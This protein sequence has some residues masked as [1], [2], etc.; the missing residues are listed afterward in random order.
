VTDLLIQI[1]I[2]FCLGVSVSVLIWSKISINWL[3]NLCRYLVWALPFERIPSVRTVIGN[4]RPSQILVLFGFYLLSILFLK[5]DKDILNH[6]LSSVTFWIIGFFV[7]SASSWFFVSD[8]SRF[9]NTLIANLIV[10]GALFLIANFARNIPKLVK[11][12]IVV[13]V[14]VA[15]FGLFQFA[16]DM[17]GL[18][19]SITGII[20]GKYSK[21][22]F[23]IPRVHG[24]AFEPIYFAAILATGIIGLCVYFLAK[25]KLYESIPEYINVIALGILLVCFALTFS[26][27]GFLA[28]PITTG[29]LLLLTFKK[30]NFK[31]FTVEVGQ[32][33]IGLGSIVLILALSV[34]S[35]F[36][37]GMN[38]YNQAIGTA[39]GAT[40]SAIERTWFFQAGT[41]QLQQNP[42]WGIGSGQFGVLGNRILEYTPYGYTQPGFYI[43][44][45]NVYLEVWLEFG[46]I[47]FIIFLV[48][49]LW[50]ILRFLQ[51]L[52][53]ATD[54]YNENILAG[55]IISF[56]LITF[57]IQWFFFSPLYIM[58][59]FIL[60][61]LLWNL[62]NLK[63]KTELSAKNL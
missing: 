54:W 28:L 7:I 31:H 61:G 52:Y 8:W 30:L 9:T 62:I 40:A 12:L 17:L 15:L 63:T 50:P 14:V 34:E 29:L 46:L 35:I 56:S 42:L 48:I 39:N 2:F 11:E 32:L 22:I 37:A 5:K 36:V 55:I 24:T 19:A 60:M 1:L 26:K 41:F 49:M 47:P 4:V 16:G 51:Q 33:V 10:F 45:Q 43:I 3:T 38:F 27:A 57:Y 21:E 20:E 59:I 53:K 58:P 44:T 18:P 6:K 25:K 23:G 13:L